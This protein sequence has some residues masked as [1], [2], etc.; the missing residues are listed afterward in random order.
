MKYNYN[1]VIP[2]EKSSRCLSQDDFDY[3][4]DTGDFPAIRPITN[5]LSGILMLCIEGNAK[6]SVYAQEY[7]LSKDQL[8]V[9]L[10]GQLVSVKEKCENFRI[11]YFLVSSLLINDVLKEIPRLSPLFFIYMRR[12]HQYKLHGDETFRIYQYF[13]L[14]GNWIKPTDK[15][16]RREYVA[17]LLRLLY[18]DLYNNYKNSLLKIETSSGRYKEQ[19][20]Y[21]FF[22]LLMT[23]FREN[24][25]IAFYADKLCLSPKY[26]TSAIKEV[27]QR[28]PKE[29]I[30]EYLIIE[31]KT[32]LKNPALNIQEITM[33]TNFSNQA[34]MSRFFKKHT[35]KS[36]TEY[37]MNK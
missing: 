21:D 36:P 4:M 17:N 37:R 28:S 15:L 12:K 8:L 16:F 35:G 30:V 24:R 19:L 20:A 2:S 9:V 10:P 1:R 5:R 7:Q 27:S 34:S 14:A 6:V 33:K 31:I 3:V 22:L 11:S 13:R 25:E 29:W 26:L 32:L 23:H 18:L